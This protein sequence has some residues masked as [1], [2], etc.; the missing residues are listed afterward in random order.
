M[1]KISISPSH[2]SHVYW[3]S[4]YWIYPFPKE[5][6]GRKLCNWTGCK[7]ECVDNKP[8]TTDRCFFDSGSFLVISGTTACTIGFTWGGL[9]APWTS[10]KVLVPLVLGF[11]GLG[12]F[13]V[14]EATRARHPLV[15]LFIVSVTQDAAYI[16]Y[17][18]CHFPY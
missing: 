5:V 10:A 4:S 12:V 6:T 16:A 15:C 7:T 18:R 17:S 8:N 9:T 2:S 11:V 3:S 14:Y 13:V 1:S